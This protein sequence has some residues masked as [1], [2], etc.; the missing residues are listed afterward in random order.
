MRTSVTTPAASSPATTRTVTRR[1]VTRRSVAAGTAWALP[2][3][4]FASAAPA[5]T[6]SPNTGVC[7]SSCI[8]PAGTDTISNTY[9]MTGSMVATTTNTADLLSTVKFGVVA[10]NCKAGL[11]TGYQITVTSATLT[12]SNGI[13]YVGTVAP[14]QTGGSL[15][16]PIAHTFG[17]T[18]PAVSLPVGTYT[19]TDAPVYPVSITFT[20]STVFA[21][22]LGGTLIADE[23]TRCAPANALPRVMQYPVLGRTGT[24]GSV[25][26]GLLTKRYTGTVTFAGGMKITP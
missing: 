11:L 21:S 22:L 10:T 18:F 9:T 17:V 12:M 4:A 7:P 2:A 16:A 19:A 13:D 23:S 5:S 15:L 24:V 1:P 8:Q 3:I 26:Q 14:N 6:S 25:T 20:Y